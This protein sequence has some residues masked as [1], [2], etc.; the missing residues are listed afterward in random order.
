MALVEY[1]TYQYRVCEP[2]KRPWGVEQWI[3]LFSGKDHVQS[4]PMNY[5]DKPPADL[6]DRIHAR[7]D[8]IDAEL[9]E[10]P[11]EPDVQ[12]MKSEVETILREK[13]Y[14]TTEQKL[15]DLPPKTVTIASRLVTG[16]KNLVARV[17]VAMKPQFPN[18]SEVA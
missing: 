17:S 10:P 12:M 6:K 2:T 9:H 15:E 1:G 4:F 14:L 13:G 7:I 8:R 16:T 11:V 3:D 5:K 18:S